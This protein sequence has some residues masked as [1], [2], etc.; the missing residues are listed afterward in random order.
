MGRRI[1][2]TYQAP[3]ALI[4]GSHGGQPISFFQRDDANPD[5]LT[6]NYG[7]L[8][9]RLVAAGVMGQVRG[10]LWYQ[11]EADSD[12]AAVHMA[13]FTSLLQDWRTDFGTAIPAAA[14]TSSTR[15]ARPP[16]ATP[17]RSTSVRRSASSA[18]PRASPCCPRTA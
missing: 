12:N 11:G 18:T 8:R 10:V 7:R 3:V 16:V 9:Q 17:R 6:T 4:N 15:Y 14:G 2:D 5:D 13:G 1:V